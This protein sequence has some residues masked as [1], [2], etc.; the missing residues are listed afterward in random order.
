MSSLLKSSRQDYTLWSTFQRLSRSEISEP[1]LE[2]GAKIIV[3]RSSIVMA[4]H[5]ILC[6]MIYQ[7]PGPPQ[8]SSKALLTCSVLVLASNRLHYEGKLPSYLQVQQTGPLFPTL[9]Y[10]LPELFMLILLFIESFKAGRVVGIA[11]ALIIVSAVAAVSWYFS[12]GK[13]SK[14]EVEVH[15]HERGAV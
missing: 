4:C 6:G 2:S 13:E 11:M 12:R 1:E 15:A 10:A 8:N 5:G 9:R 3:D 14:D 7:T